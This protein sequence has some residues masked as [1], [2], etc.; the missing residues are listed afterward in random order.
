ML[1]IYD[2]HNHRK[3]KNLKVFPNIFIITRLKFVFE[4]YIDV[5]K[6][7]FI[8]FYQTL[9]IA[10]KPKVIIVLKQNKKNWKNRIL[11]K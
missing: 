4:V 7:I 5:L 8:V 10:L 2:H 11:Y 9:S 1:S 3:P 6:V